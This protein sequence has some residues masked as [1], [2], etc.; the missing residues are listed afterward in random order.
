[1]VSQHE[2]FTTGPGQSPKILRHA[3]KGALLLSWKI[4]AAT[5]EED[6]TRTSARWVIW[7]DRDVLDNALRRSGTGPGMKVEFYH[8]R[9]F[10][11]VADCRSTTGVEGTD[12]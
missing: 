10:D 12:R 7:L 6:L 3:D 9:P 11:P 5:P 2:Q 4:Y 8:R 1:V